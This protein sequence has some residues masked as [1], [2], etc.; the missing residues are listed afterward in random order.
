VIPH[1]T[2]ASSPPPP[3]PSDLLT[4][5]P[6]CGDVIRDAFC[7]G[8]GVAFPHAQ[9]DAYTIPRPPLATCGVR[10]SAAHLPASLRR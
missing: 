2:R 4:E 3:D 6:F 1:P 10:T 8:C 5:C 7:I 9:R